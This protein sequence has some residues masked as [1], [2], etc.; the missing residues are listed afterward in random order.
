MAALDTFPDEPTASRRATP[1]LGRIHF[2]FGLAGFALFIA[3]GISMRLAGP[4]RLDA[5][6]RM[7][8]RSIHIYLFF[9]ALVH[10]SLGLSRGLR[11]TLL[12]WIG[13]SVLFASNLGLAVAFWTEPLSAT[14]PPL[15]RSLTHLCVIGFG[16]GFLLHFIAFWR[17]QSGKQ[18]VPARPLRPDSG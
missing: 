5:L 18:S 2:W 11:A 12:R 15:E 8:L 6:H 14:R 9:A 16:I 17:E 7:L 13:S 4:E 1:S 10:L 3:S